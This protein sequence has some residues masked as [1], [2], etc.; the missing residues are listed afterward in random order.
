MTNF[1]FYYIT[2]ISKGEK[3]LSTKQVREMEKRDGKNG[4]RSLITKPETRLENADGESWS[5]G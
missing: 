1:N 2:L 5:I 3:R 4:K